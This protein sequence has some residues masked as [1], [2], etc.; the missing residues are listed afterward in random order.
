MRHLSGNNSNTA[1]MLALAMSMGIGRLH[2]QPGCCRLM[3]GRLRFT[4][5]PRRL[6]ATA[7][8]AGHSTAL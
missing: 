8:T 4:V 6:L 3:A 7:I 1:G 5:D 2:C